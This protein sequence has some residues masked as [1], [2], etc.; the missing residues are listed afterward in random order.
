MEIEI[1]SRGPARGMGWDG[2]IGFDLQISTI[3]RSH[4]VGRQTKNAFWLKSV[5]RRG[6]EFATIQT[7]K[8]KNENYYSV[9]IFPFFK[10]LN[11]IKFYNDYFN[12]IFEFVRLSYRFLE[13]I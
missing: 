7:R 8:Y 11:F 10:I 3:L 5:A 12:I 9:N 1:E 2:T 6:I 13:H 4:T